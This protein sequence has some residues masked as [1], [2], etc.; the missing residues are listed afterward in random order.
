MKHE[1]LMQNLPNHVK[2]KI[3]ETGRKE[4]V[5][6]DASYTHSQHRFNIS[7]LAHY[8]IQRLHTRVTK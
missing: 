7:H 5:K 1:K 4:H 3:E 8:L 6:C 2:K